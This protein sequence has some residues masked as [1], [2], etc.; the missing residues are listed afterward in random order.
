MV[1]G[2]EGSESAEH[3]LNVLVLARTAEESITN[4]AR[5]GDYAPSPGE[6][7]NYASTNLFVLSY[8]LQ[9]YVAQQEGEGVHYWDL[10]RENVLV[11]IGAEHF[12]LRQTIE[13]DGSQG[14]PLLAYG[15]LPTLDE[16]AKIALLFA[17]EG[18]HEGQQLLHRAKVREALGHTSWTGHSTHDDFRGAHYRHSFW[19]SRVH[20]DSCEV[21][22][23]YMLGYGGNYVLFL[24]SNVVMLRFM[25]EYDF[26]VRNLVRHAEYARSLC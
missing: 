7:F 13:S 5:L 21:D 17:N 16:T 8:A 4:I 19:S 24:P 1:T 18:R 9:N 11:P 10:V 2:T 15:A 23:T 22:V 25:D 6:A 26:D 14:L 20:T 3:L 12:T